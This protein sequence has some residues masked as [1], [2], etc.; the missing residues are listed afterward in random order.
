[1][2]IVRTEED[3]AKK[4][5]EQRRVQS[6]MLLRNADKTKMLRTRDGL[7][8]DIK[9]IR[10]ALKRMEIDLQDKEAALAKIDREI[11][12]CDEEMLHLKHKLNSL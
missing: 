6:E 8:A 12:L 4:K 7:A 3:K 2:S 9:R 11:R 5:T 10:T 1:M